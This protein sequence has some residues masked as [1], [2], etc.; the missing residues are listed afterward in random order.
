MDQDFDYYQALKDQRYKALLDNQI[1]LDNARQRALKNTNT[2]MAAAGFDSSGYGQTAKMGI[3]G[4]YLQAYQQANNDYQNELFNINKDQHDEQVKQQDENYKMY[5]EMLMGASDEE[6]L[7]KAMSMAGYDVDNNV[8]NDN[9]KLS[10]I[11]K[12]GLEYAY[13]E[14]LKGYSNQSISGASYNIQEARNTITDQDGNK[15]K[16]NDEIGFLYNFPNTIPAKEGTVLLMKQSNDP[17]A[18]YTY[19]IY[20]NG[21]W[22]QTTSENYHNASS[23]NQYE[24]YSKKNNGTIFYVSHNN[25]T[26]QYNKNENSYSLSQIQSWLSD[27]GFVEENLKGEDLFDATKA[28]LLDPNPSEALKVKS[29]GYVE[30]PFGKLQKFVMKDSGKQ[31]IKYNGKYYRITSEQK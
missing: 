14:A 8:W 20:S 26:E 9:A 3:E 10:D 6:S 16:F 31:Y 21:G 24:L 25:K 1:Q 30:T 7:R 17:S 2:Q 19:L 23:E 11:S 27:N 5:S 15:G 12:T 18:K 13:Q 22:K 4:Q 29:D 28:T